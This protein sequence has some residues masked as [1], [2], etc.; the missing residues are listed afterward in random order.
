MAA[1]AVKAKTSDSVVEIPLSSLVVDYSWNGRYVGGDPNNP[2][3]TQGQGA[4]SSE[5]NDFAEFKASLAVEGQKTP[6]LVRQVRGKY[7]LI[8]GFRRYRALSEIAEESGEAGTILAIVRNVDDLQARKENLLENTERQ[9]LP[10]ADLT[11]TCGQ[12][13]AE[14]ARKKTKMTQAELGT[15]IGKSQSYTSKMITVIEG[16]DARILDEWRGMNR[17]VGFIRIYELAQKPKAEQRKLWE[18]L[19]K[20]KASAEAGNG[21]SA[22]DK[23]GKLRAKVDSIGYMLGTLVFQGAMKGDLDPN[24]AL[25]HVVKLPKN[26][27]FSQKADL[28]EALKSGFERGKN[29]GAE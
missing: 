10:P 25:E 14:Y 9:N 20:A 19:K 18:E 11:W 4:E 26:F 6:V 2:V 16:L 23:S 7:H 3:W 12:L 29:P 21:S 24:K 13:A 22:G 5:A 17:D 27:D 1:K 15:V 28:A 8:A